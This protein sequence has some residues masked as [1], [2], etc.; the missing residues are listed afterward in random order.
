MLSALGQL[1]PIAIATALSTIPITATILIL[2]SPKRDRSA[3]PFLLGWVMGMAMVVL[4]GGFLAGF[5]PQRP[6]AVSQ[7]TIGMAE[8]AVGAA[9]VVVAA[10]TWRARLRKGTSDGNRWLRAVASFGP[11]AAFGSAFAL[12]LRPKGLLLGAAA[13]LAIGGE[14]LLLSGVVVT[15]VVYLVIATS[16]V[17]APIVATL[18]APHRMEPRLAAVSAWLEKHAAAVSAIVVILVGIVIM[19][20]GLTRL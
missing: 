14:R 16:T 15:V 18:V 11:R 4:L 12:N 20:A 10:I 3:L 8:I 9:L 17:V 7:V 2:L 13:G 19:G 5:L 6:T 1:L